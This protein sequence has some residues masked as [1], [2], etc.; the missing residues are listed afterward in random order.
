M[1]LI[2]QLSDCKLEWANRQGKCQVADVPVCLIRI[3]S[4]YDDKKSTSHCWNIE[5]FKYTVR[6]KTYGSCIYD[7]LYWTYQ[8]LTDNLNYLNL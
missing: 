6:N 7:L 2:V 1:S 4:P 3:S 8:C 5:Y